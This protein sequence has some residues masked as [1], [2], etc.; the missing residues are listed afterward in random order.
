MKNKEK[1]HLINGEINTPQ[2]R[3][4]EIGV[5]SITDALNMA[6]S[7]DM[8]LVLFNVDG[9]NVGFCKLLKY[10]KYLY[11]QSKANKQKK[12]DLKEIKITPKISENDLNYRVKHIIEFLNKGHKVKITMEFKGREISYI[13][14]A[15]ALFLKLLINLE[16]YSIPEFLPKLEGKKMFS[17]LKPKK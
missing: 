10:E 15:N 14:N 13:D 1:K 17:I 9:N 4:P 5:V 7:Q 3:L 8:D 16:D 2:V 11:E 6:K 12:L